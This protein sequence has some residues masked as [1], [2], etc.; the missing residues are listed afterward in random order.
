MSNLPLNRGRGPGLNWSYY[1]SLGEK[2]GP[3]AT[4]GDRP[5]QCGWLH[6]AGGI[7]VV[8][9]PL[10]GEKSGRAAARLN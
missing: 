4:S 1:V 10:R 9:A 8:F 3:V 6:V 7:A 5:G 2:D